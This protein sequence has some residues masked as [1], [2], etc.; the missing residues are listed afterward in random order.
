LQIEGIEHRDMNIPQ[1]YKNL[2]SSV[3]SI[4]AIL[5]PGKVYEGYYKLYNKT[6]EIS[7][8]DQTPIQYSLY[9]LGY[10]PVTYIEIDEAF[11]K[12]FWIMEDESYAGLPLVY[13]PLQEVKF[14]SPFIP[15]GRWAFETTYYLVCGYL[16]NI[17]TADQD[18]IFRI[19]AKYESTFG[20]PDDI[21]IDY[22][23][24]TFWGVI[25]AAN[26]ELETSGSS[27]RIRVETWE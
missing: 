4:S 12:Q 22:S 16:L 27:F 11:Q 21:L 18:M 1:L 9:W 26:R 3:P 7:T 15:T 6:R 20:S 2:G 25:N 17:D 5:E 8:A 10:A 24:A 23:S 14:V 19:P 13:C